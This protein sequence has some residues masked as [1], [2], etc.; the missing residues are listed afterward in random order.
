MPNLKELFSVFNTT[1]FRSYFSILALFIALILCLTACF[2]DWQ[3]ENGTITI[4]LG[5]SRANNRS[6]LPLWPPDD[7]DNYFLDKIVYTITLTG[8]GQSETIHNIKGD[9]T[10]SRS[11][12]AGHWNIKIDAHIIE[13]VEN[14]GGKAMYYATGSKS[15]DVK[16]GQNITVTI[17]MKPIC[18]DC[19]EEYPCD[20][21][22]GGITITYPLYVSFNI[23]GGIGTPPATIT[24]NSK[25][26]SIMLPSNS[27]FSRDG[28][29]FDGWNTL[30]IGTGTNYNTNTA[31]IPT[32]N[33]TL[34]AKW[35]SILG[36]QSDFYGTWGVGM[37]VTI[38]ENIFIFNHYGTPY[39][40]RIDEWTPIN[41]NDND[42][43]RGYHLTLTLLSN[44][45]IWTPEFFI[46]NDR[47]SIKDNTGQILYKQ[48]EL[49]QSD[50]YGTWINSTGNYI[51][52]FSED[53]LIGINPVELLEE[54]LIIT[55]WAPAPQM[56]MLTQGQYPD[57]QRGF[58]IT[59]NFATS[60]IPFYIHNNGNSIFDRHL[61]FGSDIYYKQ[62]CTHNWQWIITTPPNFTTNTNGVE[63]K[64]CS[65]CYETDG[66]RDYL[67]YNIGDTGPAGGII[68]YVDTT[69]F[70]LY[71][72]TN[73]NITLDTYT[74]AHYLEAWTED[75]T[76]ILWSWSNEPTTPHTY[77]DVPLVQQEFDD[78]NSTQWLGYGLRNTRIIVAALNANG[79]TGRAAQ[80]STT[81]KGGFNDWFLPSVDELFAMNVA[82]VPPINVTG[83]P[84]SDWFWSSSLYNSGLVW[85]QGFSNIMVNY[86][87]AY[88]RN[89]PYSVRAIRAF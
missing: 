5:S 32:E 73:D 48:L 70:N 80:V 64:T 6:T 60:E 44:G 74:T 15:V 50:F 82:N 10:I 79:E 81:T 19:N 78:S 8:N 49:S 39:E 21:E 22:E 41:S 66:T 35:K 36:S 37:A 3:G 87:S 89:L 86:P 45:T 63:T 33:I 4:N 11:V 9:E 51:L 27:D 16:A 77:T 17:E 28:Y 23:N 83:L 20:C 84:N 65:L 62:T 52:I 14:E 88:L 47:N 56:D 13:G 58:S 59:F 31:F 43:Q 67:I 61:M 12:N 38:S 69:G 85:L 2:S 7:P 1:Y 53:K 68:F 29:T 42:Y 55:N 71:Q 76:N 25:D 40:Y 54:E 57:Y 75:V 18:Q 72:G 26:Q 24:V 30:A 46:H 34:Y